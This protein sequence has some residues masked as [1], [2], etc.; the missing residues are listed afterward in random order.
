MNNDQPI[1]IDENARLK[2]V[3]E[4]GLLDNLNPDAHFDAFTQK[5]VKELNVPISTLTILDEKK[6]HYKSCVGLDTMDGDRAISFCGQALLSRSLFVIPDCAKDPRF[7]NNPM[8]IG[9]P[10]IRFYAGTAIYD[11]TTGYPVAV[12]CIKDIKPR[13]FSLDEID[14]FLAIANEVEKEMNK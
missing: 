11:Y 3:Q 4:M 9:R 1:S 7:S 10:F 5:A 2:R 13:E 8:V 12:F 6:E 14:K